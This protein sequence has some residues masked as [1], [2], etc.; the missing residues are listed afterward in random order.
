MSD[1]EFFIS[2]RLCPQCMK[3]SLY[4]S[5]KSCPEC[6]AKMAEY[7][8][9]KRENPEYM[10]EHYSYMK[11]LRKKRTEGGRCSHCGGEKPADMYVQCEKCRIKRRIYQQK[12]RQ[13][14][15]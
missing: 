2:V 4:G 3:N 12:F 14:A 7:M 1:R 11:Q 13:K 8:A 15:G 10:Q 9:V 6:R 5:E